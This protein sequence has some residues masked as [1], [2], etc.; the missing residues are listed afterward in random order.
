MKDLLNV[1]KW[2]SSDQLISIGCG[3]AWWEINLL[4]NQ[5]CSKLF[6]VDP[7]EDLLNQQDVSETIHYFEKQY[8][9]KLDISCEI[10]NLDARQLN[11]PEKSIDGILIFNALHEI[12]NQIEVLRECKRIGKKGSFLFVEE[13][14]SLKDRFIH[15]GC[16][17]P[18]FYQN[19]LIDLIENVGF[20]FSKIHK[21]DDLASYF[22]FINE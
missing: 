5:P 16:G 8:Q 12:E 13:E 11:L 9:K 14:L 6:L 21:K 20:K 10:M 22:L 2:Q 19:E 15:E 7:N 18:L 3:G 17:F 4:F 1:L